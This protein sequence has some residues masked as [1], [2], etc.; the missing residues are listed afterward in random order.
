MDSLALE[1]ESTAIVIYKPTELPA[2]PPTPVFDEHIANFLA[3]TAEFKECT[4]RLDFENGKKLSAAGTRLKT[5]IVDSYRELKQAVDAIKTP[6]LD[7]EKADI[8]KVNNEIARIDAPAIAWLREEQRLAQLKANQEAEERR[9]A[10]LKEQQEEAQLL[11]DFGSEEE[12]KTVEA[13]PIPAERPH[14]VDT[15]LTYARGKRTALKLVATVIKPDAVKRVY[16]E[17]SARMIKAKVDSLLSANKQP[18]EEVIAALAKEI[19]G[20]KIEWQS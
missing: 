1:N 13:A 9:Q 18:S 6:I 12:A 4:S 20:I 3:Q 8:A 10:K 19:G 11:R 16:C 15:G 5:Q 14:T 2:L 17:P 7:A